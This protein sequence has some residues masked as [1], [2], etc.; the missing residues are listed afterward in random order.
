MKQRR[1]VETRQPPRAAAQE[2]P[3]DR[4]ANGDIWCQTRQR[5]IEPVICTIQSFREP[6]KCSGC[7]YASEDAARR[8]HNKKEVH[9]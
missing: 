4:Y 1:K 6:M 3:Q 5:R 7:R 9:P 2:E 8:N